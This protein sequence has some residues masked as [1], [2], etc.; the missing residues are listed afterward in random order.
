MLE[1]IQNIRQQYARIKQDPSLA[2]QRKIPG[3]TYFLD[4]NQ[5][6]SI[7]RDD[8]DSRYPYGQ[9]GFNFW[10]HTSGY[11]HSNEG[12]F[13][14]F[15]RAQEGQEPKIAFF[16]G[17]KTGEGNYKRLSL[18]SVPVIDDGMV[19]ERYT[20][21]TSE[22]VYYITETEEF[23]FVLR[24][25]VNKKKEI[26]FTLYT[27][28]KR[29][30][31]QELF[32]SSYFNPFLRHSIAEDAENRWFR[33]VRALPQGFVIKVNEDVDRTTSISN[34][35]IFTR[36]VSLSQ[37]SQLIGYEQTTS[38]YE[39][40]GGSRSSLHT[41]LSLK[42]GSF[43]KGQLVCSFD[44][45]GVAGD[46]TH[47]NLASRGSVRID[48]RMNYCFE[49]KEKERLLHEPLLP[50]QI[51]FQLEQVAKLEKQKQGNMQLRVEKGMD[52]ILKEDVFNAF[53]EQLKKQVEFCSLIKG[54]IQLAPLSLIG[55][56]D[57]FQ[58][59][60][61]FIFWQ[62]QMARTKMLEGLNYIF[63][64][65]RCPRQYSLPTH[66]KAVPVMDLRPFIDQGVWVISTIVTY[67]RLTHDFE[68]L[69]E[70][71]GYYEIVN[72]KSRL[73]KKSE[74]EDT[75]LEHMLKIMDYL[76]QHRDHEHTGCLRAMYGDWND[77]LDGLGVSQDPRKEYGTGVSVMATQ[78]LYQ[79]LHEMVDL[80][81]YLDKEKYEGIIQEY[82][83]AAHSIREGLEEYA[84]IENE[85]GEKRIVHGWGDQYS[86]FVG[87]FK[88]PDGKDRQGLTSNAFWVLSGLYD[89]RQELE[90]VIIDSFK[91]LDSKYGLKTFEPA[92][93]EKAKGVGRI[94]KLPA[95]TAENGAT[96]IHAS[97][98]GIMALFKMGYSKEAWE[99]LKKSLPFT[100]EFISCSPF[101]MPN[102]YSYNPE[103]NLDGDSMND[104]QT[105]SSNVLLKTLIRFVF[106]V[107]PTFTGLWIQPAQ[108]QPFLSFDF[109]LPIRDCL[110]TI[111]YRNEK[112]SKRKFYVNK[113]ET[114]GQWDSVMKINKLWVSNEMLKLDQLKIEI[115]D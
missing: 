94:P 55:I 115:V 44:E 99:Q 13:S 37:E 75:V 22:A 7:P 30:E 43:E 91:R 76:L 101:V 48:I 70:K 104:W 16:A 107:E 108:Y 18:L 71:C 114:E 47:F 97:M 54:Y 12:L 79:N 9:D 34:Y 40:V 38:R 6:L 41:P 111:Q 59:L 63:P 74:L 88:D 89:K 36:N 49:E 56:R 95:G 73:V 23:L 80:L 32:L 98:F 11:M 109:T 52:P 112:N 15:F 78:Q 105:G 24:V 64:D 90:N 10:A 62:P 82:K 60:E 81:H 25:F 61:G 69:D 87:S 3:N 42:K 29:A 51:E 67:L 57:V 110:V 35:G 31:H 19:A 26:L 5:I 4:Q 58:A 21:F 93:D 77:A 92:F 2:A 33:E 102:S 100:H 72:E 14:I 113:I 50:E 83:E 96:Y 45:I 86:Y 66:S 8:G 65:G 1:Q 28:N 103:K 27:E 85:K 39:Y 46:L 20:V 68:F 17:C 84:V 106:G 53:F